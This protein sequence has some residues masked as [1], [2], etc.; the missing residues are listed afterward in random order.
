[1]AKALGR[2]S[3]GHKDTKGTNSVD[4]MDLEEITQIPK[5]KIVTYARIV[6]DY[7]PQKKDKNCM[8][9]TA[10]AGGNLIN[11]PHKLTTRTAGITISQY[12]W[13]FAISTYVEPYMYVLTLFSV[14]L[15]DP[16]YSWIGHQKRTH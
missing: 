1:M 8:R 7:R 4:F 9:I 3:Q 16:E 10:G 11:Y 5:G 13:N 15:K 2:L 6:V 14:P 12:M